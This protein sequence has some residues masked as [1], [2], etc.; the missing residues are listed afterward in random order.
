MRT[1]LVL[2]AVVLSAAVI[3]M[4]VVPVSMAY[5]ADA[6][7]GLVG[8]LD[9]VARHCAFSREGAAAPL[10]LWPALSAFIGSTVGLAL[11][12]RGM[13]RMRWSRRL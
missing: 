7:F 3:L 8:E 11:L 10:A 13:L 6:C 5:G 4:C 1:H 2:T 12:R 9:V